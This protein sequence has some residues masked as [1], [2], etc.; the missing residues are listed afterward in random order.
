[1]KTRYTMRIVHLCEFSSGICGTWNAVF[2]T[3]KR[4]AKEHEVYVFSSNIERGSGKR[5]E[6][7]E[8]KE[9]VRILRFPLK[10][11]LSSNYLFWD[12][13]HALDE[14]KPEIIHAHVYRHS[15]SHKAAKA[16]ITAKG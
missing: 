1:M 13:G 3:A 14:I 4:Q 5:V 11:S 10:F 16:V 15:Y 2:E 7:R 9:G 6:P 12:F 8:V